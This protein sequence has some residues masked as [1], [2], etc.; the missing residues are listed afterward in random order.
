MSAY[1]ESRRQLVHISMVG[2]AALLRY[3]TW[4]QAAMLASSALAFNLFL[5]PRVAP[6]ILRPTDAGGHR[7]GVIFYP[8]SVLILVLVFRSRLDIVAAAWAVM[9]FGDGTATLAGT[10]LRGP[11]LPWNRDKTWSGLVGFVVAGSVGAVAMSL[12]VAP[13]IAPVPSPIITFWAPIAATI[14]AALVE[15]IPV[16]LDDNLSVPFAAGLVLALAST[17]SSDAL[18]FARPMLAERLHWALGINV[19]MAAGAQLA[20]SITWGAAVSGAVIGIVIYLGAGLSGWSLLL[21][22]FGCAVISSR[23]GLNRKIARGISEGREGRRGPGNAI[24]NCVV[25]AIGGWLMI[26]E[27]S[28]IRGALVLASGLIAGASDTVASEI[29]KAFGGRPRAFP[30]FLEVQHGTP[31]GV[32]MIGTLAG[33]VAAVVMSLYAGASLPGGGAL[34][35]PIVVGATAGAFA[36]SAL[37]G[38]FEPEGVL[39]NDLLNF[40]NTAI[41]AGVA[42]WVAS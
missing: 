33:L 5:L 13:A 19:V 41:A 23:L 39:N 22:S 25:G 12:W 35:L 32:S 21:L 30:S 10:W 31:G 18:A 3:V 11:R 40:L 15:T 17:V 20:G 24:A 4:P 28:D 37:A 34:V 14:A 8:L 26:V 27:P 36:E 9:A 38:R 29:G 42:V 1:S 16:K 7:A 6:G 2:F